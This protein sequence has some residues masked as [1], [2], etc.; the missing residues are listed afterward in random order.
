MK[1]CGLRFNLFLCAT[2]LL[3]L[4]VTPGCS[5]K[6][7]KRKSQPSTLRVHLEV[8]PDGRSNNGPVPIYRAQPVM[9]NV[10]LTPML[11][12][13]NVAGA[14]VIDVV[15]GFALRIQFDQRGS[16]ILEQRTVES[17]GRRFAIFCQFGAE[18]KESRWLAA[19]IIGRRIT[20]GVLVFTPDA[21]RAEADDLVLGLNNIARVAKTKL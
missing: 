21:T 9:V 19:P 6:E 8:Q 14:R 3:A 15:G 13:A 1:T 4:A 2:L 7:R 12:E 11:T 10:D 20:D 17:R 18:L 16:W 5:L